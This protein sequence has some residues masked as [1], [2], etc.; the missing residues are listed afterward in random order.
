M[1]ILIEGPDGSG[2]STLG[3]KLS[4][5]T[6]R[7]YTILRM[8]GKPENQS[9]ADERLK[10]FMALARIDG[11][12]FDRSFPISEYIYG[13]LFRTTPMVSLKEVAVYIAELMTNNVEIYYCRTLYNHVEDPSNDPELEKLGSKNQETARDAYDKLFFGDLNRL[14]PINTYHNFHTL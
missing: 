10:W 2:K 8:S 9:V 6:Y 5:R 1:S 13:T 11:L 3:E 4:K 14:V 12:I 7:P